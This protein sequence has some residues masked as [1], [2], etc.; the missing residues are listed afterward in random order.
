MGG[1]HEKPCGAGGVAASCAFFRVRTFCQPTFQPI[2]ILGILIVAVGEVLNGYHHWLL[3]RLRQLGVRI[4]VVPR[5]GLF[6]WVACPHYLGEILSFV[7]YA[8]MS[9][10]LPVWGNTLVASAYLS[11]KANSTLN[12]YRREKPLT[13]PSRWDRLIPF[14]Y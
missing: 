1:G 10:L 9:D 2:F 5:H 12:W 3:A 4:Y 6:G 13:I 7:G 14:A 8:M 11:A